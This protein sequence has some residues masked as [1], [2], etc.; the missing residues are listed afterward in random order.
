[1]ADLS[2]EAANAAVTEDEAILGGEAVF[3]GT[4]VPVRLI[5]TMLADGVADEEI[6]SGYPA[7]ERNYLPLASL[8]VAAH[9]LRNQPKTLKERGYAPISTKRIPLGSTA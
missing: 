5:A 8:W 1:M 7:L 6:L 9:P 3:K 2:L 4:R